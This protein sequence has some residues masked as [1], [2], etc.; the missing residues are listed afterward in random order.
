VTEISGMQS[1]KL[2]SEKYMLELNKHLLHII[3]T[4]SLEYSRAFLYRQSRR[5]KGFF[6]KKLEWPQSPSINYPTVILQSRKS[7]T[8]M[9]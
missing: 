4:A 6:I 8:P 3:E 9:E 1:G 7:K 2:S 5:R